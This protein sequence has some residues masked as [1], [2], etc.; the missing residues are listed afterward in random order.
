MKNGE[1]VWE[2]GFIDSGISL[3]DTSAEA[4]EKQAKTIVCICE[5][6]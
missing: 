6:K 3:Q 1:L 5:G 4:R 2:N